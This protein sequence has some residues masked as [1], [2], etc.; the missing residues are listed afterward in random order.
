MAGSQARTDDTPGAWLWQANLVVNGP[1]ALPAKRAGRDTPAQK[2]EA[3]RRGGGILQM[4]SQRP[5]ESCSLA[6]KFR[7]W[8]VFALLRRRIYFGCHCLPGTEVRNQINHRIPP[9]YSVSH[10]GGSSGNC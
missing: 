1:E 3:A 7:L 10:Q 8:G 6:D 5:P 2:A 9:A 4:A